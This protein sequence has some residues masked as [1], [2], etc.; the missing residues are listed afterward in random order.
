[1]MA[2]ESH[3]GLNLTGEEHVSVF[4]SS[5]WAERGFCSRCGTHLF[6]RLRSGELHGVP[7]SLLDE[8]P[9]WHFEQQIFVDEQP[10]WYAFANSTRDLTGEEVFAMFQPPAD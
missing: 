4:V 6:Y 9:D 1:M 10:S 7:V 2:V 8:R 5:D 3:S